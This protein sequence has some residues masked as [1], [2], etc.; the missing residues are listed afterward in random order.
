MFISYILVNKYLCSDIYIDKYSY[1]I[2][3]RTSR[4]SITRLSPTGQGKLSPKN[5]PQNVFFPPEKDFL[6]IE[7]DAG[8]N[9]YMYIYI[10]I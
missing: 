9:L 3:K 4:L 8:M 10:Y 2:R 1:I 5:S 6:P 7:L